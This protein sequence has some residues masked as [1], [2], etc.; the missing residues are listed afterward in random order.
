MRWLCWSLIR[1]VLGKFL[2]RMNTS[3]VFEYYIFHS[4]AWPITE[5][6]EKIDVSYYFSTW[7]PIKGYSHTLNLRFDHLL[8]NWCFF[9]WGRLFRKPLFFNNPCSGGCLI[10]NC[11]GNSWIDQHW[12]RPWHALPYQRQY[13]LPWP[14]NSLISCKASQSQAE[15][16][17]W[18]TYFH[19]KECQWCRWA[20]WVYVEYKQLLPLCLNICYC[21]LLARNGM[22][23]PDALP[24]VVA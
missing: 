21:F 16:T 17:S 13:V 14:G 11:R 18:C 3:L 5:L 10:R 15:S 2:P 8:K 19:Q 20:W 6:N 9:K 7:I 1:I 4:I 23:W 24:S 12:A 22:R